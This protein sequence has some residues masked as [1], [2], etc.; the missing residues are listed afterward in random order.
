MRL[1]GAKVLG[2]GNMK[3]LFFA[4]G[5]AL[6]VASGCTVQKEMVPTGGSRSD[7]TVNLSYEYGIFERPQVNAAQAET[8][9]QQRCEVWGYTGAEPFGG[10]LTRCEVMNGY[11]ECLR[12][13]VTVTYQC[14]GNPTASGNARARAPQTSDPFAGN[15][16]ATGSDPF[17]H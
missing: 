3:R 11:G 2:G 10:A 14:T 12:T 7:G 1:Y 5:A 9:A 8:S 15:R 4:A 13:L 6:L 16:P 17:N